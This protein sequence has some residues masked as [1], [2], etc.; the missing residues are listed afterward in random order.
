MDKISLNYLWPPVPNKGYDPVQEENGFFHC[1]RENQINPKYVNSDHD[2][3]DGKWLACCP[4]YGMPCTSCRLIS[5][6]KADKLE[7]HKS[8]SKWVG[9]SGLV[10]C[11]KCY[12]PK[13]GTVL[14]CEECQKE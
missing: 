11:D 4:E 13:E 7:K 8:G 9:L 6:P 14:N 5:T 10:Y 12:P 3:E 2:K 1:R